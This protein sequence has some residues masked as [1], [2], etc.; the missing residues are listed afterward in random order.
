[1]YRNHNL[2]IS[3]AP[4]TA[5]SWELAYLQGLSQNTIDRQVVSK[6]VISHIPKKVRHADSKMAKVLGV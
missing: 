1:M 4:E 3:T 5:E 2:K 6:S